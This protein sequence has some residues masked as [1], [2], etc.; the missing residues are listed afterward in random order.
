MVTNLHDLCQE[1]INRIGQNGKIKRL[2]RDLRD[3]IDSERAKN[4]QGTLEK[5]EGDL[6][7][8]KQEN[9]DLLSKLRV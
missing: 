7:V 8:I 9:L 2:V 6:N 5:M 1:I 3:Q 4:T